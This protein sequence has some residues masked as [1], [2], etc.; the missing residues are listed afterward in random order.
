MA[1]IRNTPITLCESDSHKIIDFGSL[2]AL[3]ESDY[4]QIKDLGSLLF[5]KVGVNG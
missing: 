5:F 3:C 2:L 1:I 4:Q